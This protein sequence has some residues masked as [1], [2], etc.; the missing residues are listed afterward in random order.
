[1]KRLVIVSFGHAD[2]IL[3]YASSLSSAYEVELIFVF[4]L[5]KRAE[6]VLNFEN[7]DLTTGFLPDK[8][9]ER[10]L[11][12]AITDF[13]NNKFKVRFFINY[14]LKV[15]SLKNIGLALNLAKE[16]NNFDLI[17]FNGM[18]ATLLLINYFLSKKKKRVFTIHDVKLH[19]GERGNS[20]LNIAETYIKLLLK[21]KYQVILQN[22]A[23]YKEVLREYP[24]RKTKI[25]FIPFK[26]LSIFRHFADKTKKYEDSDILFFGRISR[27]KGLRFLVEAVDLL[28]SKFPEIKIIV[29]GSGQIDKEINSEKFNKNIILYNRYISNEEMA[30]LITN[31]KIVV[32]PYT[33]ATQSGVV[34]TSFAFGKPVIAS[35]VGGFNDVIENGKTGIL[36]PP[37]DSG[38][39][40]EAISELLSDKEKLM[41]MQSGISEVC[42]NGYLSWNSV[43]EDAEKVYLKALKNN[44]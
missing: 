1:M 41:K 10:I 26:C 27:Y 6:S 14:N 3:H 38:K 32:C 24:T 22:K 35:A 7:E 12:N 31:T 25:N 28:K 19:S 29:A 9:V 13:V 40:A 20:S 5:N 37:A 11:G 4:A 8:Q 34:M 17:H 33:D 21:S 39:L 18:D 16:L 2:S 15:R 36:V 23:D 42:E 30:G 44:G 43:A